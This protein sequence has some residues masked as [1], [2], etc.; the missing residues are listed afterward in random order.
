[1][2]LSPLAGKPAPRAILTNIPRLIS[3]YYTHIPD[4]ENPAHQVAF[5]TS[6][7]RGSSVRCS[8]NERHILAITQAICDYRRAQGIDGPLF[9]GM[10]SHALSEPA[11]NPTEVFPLRLAPGER[12]YLTAWYRVT[13]CRAIEEVD[14]DDDRIELRVRIADGPASWVTSERRIDAQNLAP[15]DSG[16]TS[17]PAGLARRACAG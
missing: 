17:W 15:D 9:L 5:G 4:P 8:F 12:V 6:G 14:P 1:M 16:P 11:E 3:A 10:D 7:H 2:P 13:D